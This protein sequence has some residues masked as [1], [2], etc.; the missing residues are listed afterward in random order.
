MEIK[1]VLNTRQELALSPRLYQSL[2][3]LRLTAFDLQELIQKEL[4]E[5]PALEIPETPE[6]TETGAE[7]ADQGLWDEYLSA[8]RDSTAADRRQG[9]PLNPTELT[10]S[11]VTLADHL[12]LQLDLENL[13]AA[14]RAI[15]AAIIGSLDDHGYLRESLETLARAAGRQPAEVSAV[16][17]RVQRFDPPGIAAR[18]LEECLL[19][20]LDQLQDDTIA[21][22]IITDHLSRLARNDITGIARSLAVHPERVKKAVALIRGL[23]PSPGARFDTA[24]PAGAIIP[25]VYISQD[26]NGVHILANRDILPSL[27]LSSICQELAAAGKGAMDEETHSYVRARLRTAA[28]LIR[29]IDQRRTT[30]TRVAEA[31]AAA[32]PGFFRYGPAGLRPLSLDDIASRL[33]VH[34][35]TVSRSIIGK[36]MS[37][38]FGVFEFRYF[39]ASGYDNGSSEGVAATAVKQRL[40][41]LIAAEDPRRPLSDQKLADLLK[42]E[43]IDISRRT[44]AKYREQAGIPPSWQRKREAS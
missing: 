20:Q 11:P 26:R 37:T 4:D 34:P 12:S 8:N 5:N 38:P 39:F 16:L 36:Y 24:P 9:V 31:I 42:L 33:E 19:L 32:Q 22:K 44:V 15:G 13:S 25:D 10:A 6:S 3:I 18:S 2:R 30:V 7:A 41:E 28:Q 17:K 1:P 29:D 35:S 43:Q 27:K 21:R 14:E 23:D 40:S